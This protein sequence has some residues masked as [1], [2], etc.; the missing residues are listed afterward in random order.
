MLLLLHACQRFSRHGVRRRL[1]LLHL[2]MLL[3][4]LLLRRCLLLLHE[5]LLLLLHL[6]LHHLHFL[7]LDAF[8]HFGFRGFFFLFKPDFHGSFVVVAGSGS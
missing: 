5:L 2:L 8:H 6:K 3:H 4:W 1:T 7:G